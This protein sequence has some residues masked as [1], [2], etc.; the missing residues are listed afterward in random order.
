[1]K[2][3]S[4]TP[5]PPCGKI[6][7]VQPCPGL[8]ADGSHWTDARGALYDLTTAPTLTLDEACADPLLAGLGFATPGSIGAIVLQERL[9]PVFRL[10]DRVVRIFHCALQDF[11]FRQLRPRAARVA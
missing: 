8:S 6:Y 11:R 3:P 10:N 7:G 1:M 9:Y 2:P 4:K 5:P